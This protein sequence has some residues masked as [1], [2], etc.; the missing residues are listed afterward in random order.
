MSER[1]RSF[2]AFDIDSEPVLRK[3]SEAQGHL[4]NTGANL[5]LVQP[6]NV[7]IT[8]RFLGNISFNMVDAIHNE[9]NKV[10]FTPFDVEILGLGAFPSLKYARVV[11]AGIRKGAEALSNISSKLEP[12]LQKLGFKPDR[13]G[14]S[15]HL[16]IARV[17]TGRNKA[18]LAR[19]IEELAEFR[20]GILGANC[21]KLKKSVL[22]PKGPIYST[23]R[24]T[25][26]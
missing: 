8:M 13:K 4:A 2:I 17:R 26:H 21:L 12:S 7:H 23:L 6:R 18:E 20:F 9:M 25:S 22:T 14:F 1:I 10:S 11:W 5:K 15:P 19:C 16:T 3:L 24:E